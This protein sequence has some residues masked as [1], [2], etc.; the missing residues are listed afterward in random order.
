MCYN[1]ADHKVGESVDAAGDHK[2][3]FVLFLILLLAKPALAD[4]PRVV[5]DIKPVYLIAS[6]VMDGVG[7]AQVL[8]PPGTSPHHYAMR[9]S[10][11][12][13]LTTAD[14]VIWV[15]PALTLWLETPLQTLAPDAITITLAAVPGTTALLLR[16]AATLLDGHDEHDHDHDHGHAHEGD[17]DPHMWLMPQ[18]AAVWAVHI[19]DQL[20]ALDPEHG[21]QYRANAAGFVAELE[22]LAKL[23][24]I[25]G[26]FFV[27][28]DAFH[29]LEEGIGAEAVAV[30]DVADT[31]PAPRV[32]AAFKALL[33]ENGARC[34]ISDLAHGAGVAA[35]LDDPDVRLAVLDPMG[36]NASTYPALIENLAR[37]L[38]ACISG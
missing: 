11:A 24:Q 14:V 8:L 38:Q 10:D 15:G 2:M 26:A 1:I 22:A 27:L 12:R 30:L 37:E 16:E 25:E 31:A 3:R 20:A 35:A 7:E 13:K 19:A 4:A 9:P 17:L 36:E 33:A 21:E 34:L 18:N 29:Y 23:E 28:H 32:L 5:A 6:A